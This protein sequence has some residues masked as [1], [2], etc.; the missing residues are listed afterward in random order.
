M[1]KDRLLIRIDNEGHPVRLF[2]VVSSSQLIL[3]KNFCRA[4]FSNELNPQF[5]CFEILIQNFRE[6]CCVTVNNYDCKLS[7]CTCSFYQKN[8]KCNHVTA[9][10]IKYKVQGCNFNS[11]I[12]E[13]KLRNKAN[14]GRKPKR[15]QALV[16]EHVDVK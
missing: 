10:C 9:L 16:R 8:N 4:F 11:V 12:M 14:R 6:I 2:R 1:T 5:D 13:M 7:N 3:N 15:K